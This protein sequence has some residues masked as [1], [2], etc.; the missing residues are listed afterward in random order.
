MG[1]L[2]HDTADDNRVNDEVNKIRVELRAAALLQLTYDRL[3]RK[4]FPV[5]TVRCH[6]VR[7]I[8]DHD[9]SCAEWNRFACYAIRVAVPVPAFVMAAHS[10]LDC[11]SKTRDN[12]NKVG[13][14]R[15]V[16]LQ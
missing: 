5:G 12:P 13:A 14:L 3:N 11:P 9:N 8:G 1:D 7:C 4:L 2:S 15:R 6:C 10:I 16:G